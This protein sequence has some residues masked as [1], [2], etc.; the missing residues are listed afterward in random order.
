MLRISEGQ[1]TGMDAR[2]RESVDARVRHRL[3]EQH[4]DVLSKEHGAEIDAL[5]GRLKALGFTGYPELYGAADL[6]I[7][8]GKRKDEGA[9]EARAIVDA[10]F[11]RTE[12]A[13]AARLSF[14]RTQELVRP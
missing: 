5:I 13:P 4:R 3:I 8:V 7:A 11:S 2:H 1:L 6:L 12:Q 9:A 10:V 14:L